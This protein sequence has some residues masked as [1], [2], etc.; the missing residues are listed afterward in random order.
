MTGGADRRPERGV[1][2]T[3]IV[4]LLRHLDSSH[5][6]VRPA[7]STV[8]LAEL[9]VGPLIASDADERARRQG[10]LQQAEADFEPL[11]FGVAAARSFAVVA[12]DMRHAGRKASAR[13]FDAMIAATAMAHRLPL[14]TANPDD[15][16]RI[17]GLEVVRVPVSSR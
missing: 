8:T 7:V 3:N 15:F 9:S 17:D 10:H 14:F 4:I 13:S 2:D 16:A 1:V 6:P 5:L 11:A 12:A